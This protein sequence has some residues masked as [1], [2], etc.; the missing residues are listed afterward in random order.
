MMQRDF[1]CDGDIETVLAVHAMYLRKQYGCGKANLM[2]CATVET[3]RRA[4]LIAWLGRLWYL[5][6]LARW[7]G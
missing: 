2:A 5:L 1:W 3:L 7:G 6:S 4:K